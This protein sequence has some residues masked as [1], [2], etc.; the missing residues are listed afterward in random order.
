MVFDLDMFDMRCAPN[1]LLTH[2]RILRAGLPMAD[3]RRHSN[4]EQ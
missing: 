1:N 4:R 3:G 2:I